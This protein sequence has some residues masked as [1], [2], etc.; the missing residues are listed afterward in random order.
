MSTPRTLLVIAG[1]RPEIIKQAPLVFAAR[2][3]PRWRCIVCFSGQHADM[4]RQILADLS[5]TADCELNLMRPGATPDAFLGAAVPA[6]RQVMEQHRPDWVAVQGDTTTALAGAIAA[7][8]ARIP[9]VH[10]EAGLRTYQRDLPFPE[11]IHRQLITRVACAHAAPT[12]VTAGNLHR[13]GIPPAAVLTAGNTGIDCLLQVTSRQRLEGYVPSD[14]PPDVIAAA[15]A[16][17][18]DRW[19]RPLVLVTLHRRESIGESMRGMCRAIRRV[20]AQCSRATFL[21]PVHLNPEVRAIV[22]SEL[23][24]ESNV[25]LTEPLGYPTFAWLLDRCAFVLTDSGGIQEEAPALGKPVLVLRDVTERPEAIACGAA[26]LVGCR[27]EQIVTSALRLLED[28][29]AYTRMAVPRFP[30]GD[31]RASERILDWL[32][33]FGAGGQPPQNQA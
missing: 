33:T 8:Y 7:F 25:L 10:I 1:T 17:C 11:E 13:E 18:A 22:R 26:E 9:A 24:S 23:A 2:H 32:L 12:D 28:R 5:L 27:E 6:L 3:D 16:P 30:Y 31:G 4:G 14:L 15:G 20:A 19:E 21:L 29:A